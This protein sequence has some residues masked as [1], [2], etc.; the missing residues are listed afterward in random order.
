[1][2]LLVRW[3]VLYLVLRQVLQLVV[4]LARSQRSKK[5][6]ILVLRHQLAILRREKP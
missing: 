5:L 6:A 1:V 2:G 3:L 4:L